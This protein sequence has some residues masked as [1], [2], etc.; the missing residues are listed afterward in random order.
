[1]FDYVLSM[2]DVSNK[3]PNPEVYN[4]IIEHYNAK[5]EECLIFEDSYT[6]VLAAKNAGCEVVNIYDKY[7]DI[8]RD[9][10]NELAELE[11]KRKNIE[12]QSEE[13]NKGI[14]ESSQKAKMDKINKYKQL[15]KEKEEVNIIVHDQNQKKNTNMKNQIEKIKKM[16]ENNK[17][18]A[19]KRKKMLNK[20]SMDLNEKKY[21]NNIEKT[22]LL[23]MQMRQLQT[24]ED[25]CLAKLNR[26][27]E[28]LYTYGSMEKIYFGKNKKKLRKNS[29][30]MSIKSLEDKE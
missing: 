8:D 27:K 25:E 5:K 13:M 11:Q 28:R 20:S 4:K 12:K 15:Q 19:I 3:K 22:K 14:K 18:Y 1:M 9:K 26:T 6:G 30:K 17:N 2:E 10:I 21:E 23:K 7:S 16:Q 29:D 24:E